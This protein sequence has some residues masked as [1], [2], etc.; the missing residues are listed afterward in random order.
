M[1]KYLLV[2]KET[3]EAVQGEVTITTIK[4]HA[5]RE[6]TCMIKQCGTSLDAE[7]AHFGPD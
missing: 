4:T 7:N 1:K 5:N 3:R 6:G 2:V